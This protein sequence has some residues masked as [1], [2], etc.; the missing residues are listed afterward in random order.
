MDQ[1]IEIAVAGYDIDSVGYYNRAIRN[2]EVAE[3]ELKADYFFYA[4]LEFR[5]CI[6]R[7]LFEYLYLTGNRN[8]DPKWE[9]VCRPTRLKD[10]I[11]GVEPDFYKKL[12]FANLQ[13]KA[14]GFTETYIIDLDTFSE[15]YGKLGNFLHASKRGDKTIDNPRW[16]GRLYQL[17]CDIRT[18]LTR[19]FNH[20]MGYVHLNER[21]WD[22][23]ERWIKGEATEEQ[24]LTEFK[25]ALEQRREDSA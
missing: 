24:V 3:R 4:A 17:L 5:N 1:P 25:Q 15:I 11:L 16:W 20:N 19:V 21:G 6:E 23:Y 10:E 2:L 9:K 18:M 12:Q 14:I 7:L 13:M 8:W 22:L